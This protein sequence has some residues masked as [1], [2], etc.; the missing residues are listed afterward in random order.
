MTHQHEE[1]AEVLLE[2]VDGCDLSAL[3]TL[4]MLANGDDPGVWVP[5]AALVG[6]LRGELERSGAGVVGGG[7]EARVPAWEGASRVS[8]EEH[9]YF[10]QHV[11]SMLLRLGMVE[12][13]GDDGTED[14][15]V[16]L[17]AVRPW[18]SAAGWG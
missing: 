13:R 10:Q 9:D 15:L 2:R 18:G 4:R 7:A 8:Q 3:L 5:G 1:S 17:G 6:R 14:G 12:T 11:L 16:R